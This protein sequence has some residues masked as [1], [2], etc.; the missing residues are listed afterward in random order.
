M[1]QQEFHTLLRF[2]KVLADE[3]RLKILGILANRECSVEEL[4]A[5]LKLKEPTVSHHLAKLKELHL[6]NMRSLG[7]T[8]LYQLNNKALQSISKDIFS[9]NQMASLAVDVEGE[10]WERKVLKNFLEGD[11]L[12][13]DH[14]VRLKDIPASRK[15]RLVILKWLADQF[16]M[17]VNYPEST[18]ND[19]LKRYHLDYATLR[20]ELI[21]CQLMQREN[22]VYWRLAKD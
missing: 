14:D 5:L 6:V 21:G 4:A 7:N 18:V 2:F 3:T 22:G 15:K 11:Y 9:P 20:R 13:N 19:I 16:E 8:H 17:G 1:E 10:A 12:T